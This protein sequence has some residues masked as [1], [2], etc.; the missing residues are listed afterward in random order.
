MTTSETRRLL[1]DRLLDAK[2]PFI[3]LYLNTEAAR[4]Q[5]WEETNLRFKALREQAA[6]AGA[7]EETLVALDARVDRPHLL[8]NGL[9]V[10]VAGDS[11]VME[12]HLARAIDDDITF[13]AVPNLVPLIE[14]EQA[15]PSYAVV[16]ADRT[17]AEI[18]V[19]HK[20]SI[21][22]S[23]EV[24][25]DLTKQDVA[26]PQPGG[27]SQARFQRRAENLWEASAKEVADE[28]GRVAQTED[29]NFILVA[30]DVSAVRHLKHHAADHVGPLLIDV[31]VQPNDLSEIQDELENA[32]STFVGQGMKELLDKFQEER[33]QD[34][35][36]T[37]G[38]DQ[39]MAAVRMSQ[40]GTLLIA[41]DVEDRA[42]FFVDADPTQCSTDRGVLEGLGLGDVVEAPARD[43]VVRA[44]LATGADVR[45]IPS[46]AAEHGPRAGV[47]SLLRFDPRP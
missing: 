15:N 31:D 44:A 40:V 35:L 9:A 3:S 22:R 19:V 10:I 45:V 46:L 4:E 32:L 21:T 36:A 14:W 25:R 27:W 37:E 17:G 16:L 38:W 6:E 41:S 18:H 30:G 42:A 28:L 23:I 39:T 5:A 8:G 13:G 1:P 26:M 20:Q 11:V 7:P 43:I 34:D 12:R 47:G 33:G 24:E 29:L 2:G